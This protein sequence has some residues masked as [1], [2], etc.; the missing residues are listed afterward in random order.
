MLTT[1]RSHYGHQHPPFLTLGTI[2]E[3]LHDDEQKSY[4]LCIQPRCD[5]VRLDKK[6]PFPFLSLDLSSEEGE[7]DMVV[8]NGKQETVY[9][10]V[11]TKPSMC[12]IIEFTPSSP[13]IGV[14]RTQRDDTKAL[15]F[16]EVEGLRY[17]Y[18]HELKEGY[19]QRVVNSFAS[20]I[21]RVG[22]NELEWLRRS[23]RKH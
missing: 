19:A 22:L 11:I 7:F 14:I 23:A 8:K 17:R 10:K 13:D 15:W 12:R 6:T 18:L 3:E 16:P 4:L 5:S 1:L 9:L 21:S 20:E 2:V